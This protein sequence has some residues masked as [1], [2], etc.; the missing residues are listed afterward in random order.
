MKEPIRVFKNKEQLDKSLKEWQDRLFLNDWTI[1]AVIEKFSEDEEYF[2]GEC[3]R[4]PVEKFA[5]IRIN[6]NDCFVELNGIK[7]AKRPQEMVLVH[8]LLHCKYTFI[9]KDSSY[10]SKTTYYI[11]HYLIEEMAKSLIMAKYNLSFDWFKVDNGT[12]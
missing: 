8:E 5:L 11:E 7:I 4:L 3:I 9:E 1:K 12:S 10:E 2:G 6:K